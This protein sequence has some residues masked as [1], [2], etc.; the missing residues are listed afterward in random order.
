MKNKKLN[1]QLYILTFF[2][3]GGFQ[4]AEQASASPSH[5]F[6]S[7]AV[8]SSLENLKGQTD[9]LQQEIQKLT[10][11][12]NTA[13][14]KASS[15]N[16]ETNEKIIPAITTHSNGR[17]L[18]EV[19]LV[20][21]HDSYTHGD[22]NLHKLKAVQNNI[23]NLS[24]QV[25]ILTNYINSFSQHAR[26]AKQINAE[27]RREYIR[28]KQKVG[29]QVRQVAH[30]PSSS[31]QQ[32]G[33]GEQIGQAFQQVNNTL[34]PNATIPSFRG[35]EYDSWKEYWDARNEYEMMNSK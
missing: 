4:L 12:F 18:P 11:D 27:K 35:Q 32:Q 20:R 28:L 3:A 30:T 14:F 19:I 5:V 31:P 10:Q 25:H 1:F 2:L 17:S 24:E 22:F 33:V 15:L 7:R 16:G 13:V 23:T 29:G 8:S 34:F 26:Q 21:N 9:Q 6:N